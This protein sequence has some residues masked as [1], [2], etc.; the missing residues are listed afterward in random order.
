MNNII[1][2]NSPD[3]K[4][5]KDLTFYQL[6]QLLIQMG[7]NS[8]EKN[9]VVELARMILGFSQDSFNGKALNEIDYAFEAGK[10]KLS[11]SISDKKF[12]FKIK[13]S[14][15][16]VN[17][18]IQFFL[19]NQIQ[20]NAHYIVIFYS[21]I[22]KLTFAHCDINL[23]S[24]LTEKSIEIK[25]KINEMIKNNVSSEFKKDLQQFTL[26]SEMKK[27]EKLQSIISEANSTLIVKQLAEKKLVET[28]NEI[29]NN[30]MARA[31]KSLI[32][33]DRKLD[34]SKN[35]SFS[36]TKGF[37]GIEKGKHLLCFTN[38]K[39]LSKYILY[40]SEINNDE[41]IWDIEI[42]FC[43]IK[44]R[45][46]INYE[47]YKLNKITNQKELIESRTLKS[48]NHE[49]YQAHIIDLIPTIKN[50]FSEVYYE[51]VQH[52][53]KL[54][55]G[56]TVKSEKDEHTTNSNSKIIFEFCECTDVKNTFAVNEIEIKIKK[57]DMNLAF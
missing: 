21:K 46:F 30:S 33:N 29:K 22:D 37:I 15:D 41:C 28:L 4:I 35:I 8:E 45:V 50:L 38:E 36:R 27:I 42:S 40:E 6:F 17:E 7:P 56:K 11:I 2:S 9:K 44:K 18:N 31:I 53:R 23:R 26:N 54:K 25:D 12:E 14:L 16:D 19:I 47:C 55:N 5:F 39:N 57:P 13:Q 51:K 52:F 20:S 48:E 34:V 24:R 49:S 3:N 1:Q 10:K 43:Q 32:K